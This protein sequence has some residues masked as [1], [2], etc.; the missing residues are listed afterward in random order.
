MVKPASDSS[1]PDLCTGL[2]MNG[3]VHATRFGLCRS[4]GEANLPE[5]P[6]SLPP[7]GSY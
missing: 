5:C 2:S 3:H 1:D 4:R 6:S 7:V